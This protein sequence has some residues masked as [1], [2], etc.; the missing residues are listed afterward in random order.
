ME[1]WIGTN[2][3]ITVKKAELADLQKYDPIIFWSPELEICICHVFTEV[4]EGF[5]ITKSLIYNHEDPPTDPKYLLGK[6]I[7]PKFKWYHRLLF[8]YIKHDD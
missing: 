5:I 8:K 6:V 3:V 4:R 7:E 1:P 2:E